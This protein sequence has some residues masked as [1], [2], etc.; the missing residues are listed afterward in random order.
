MHQIPTLP[1]F[2]LLLFVFFCISST[3]FT[4]LLL[5]V[6]LLLIFVLAFVFFPDHGQVQRD[7]WRGTGGTGPFLLAVAS[8]RRPGQR[9]TENIYQNLIKSVGLI[10]C[11]SSLPGSF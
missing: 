5:L 4:L 11:F 7:R 10:F 9:M 3:I 2:F 6:R 8:F 1:A